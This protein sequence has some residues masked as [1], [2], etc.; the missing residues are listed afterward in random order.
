MPFAG[1]PNRQRFGRWLDVLSTS[2]DTEIIPAGSAW[3]QR[4][5]GLFLS[6]PDKEWSLTDCISFCVMQERGLE[7]ALTHAHHFI[8]AGFRALLR[9]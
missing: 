9:E 2:P 4:G 6:R 3:F 7:G 8:Q 5:R 1:G